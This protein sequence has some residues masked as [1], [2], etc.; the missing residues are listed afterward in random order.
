MHVFNHFYLISVLCVFNRGF[1]ESK[2][3]KEEF[4]LALAHAAV[5]DRKKLL[6]PVLCDEIKVKN[7]PPELK[8][9][10]ETHTYVECEVGVLR[11]DI[12]T[13]TESESTVNIIIQSSHLQI[14]FRVEIPRFVLYQEHFLI[15]DLNLRSMKQK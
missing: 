12:E 11:D 8:F 9:Y 1:T 15:L 7:L 14:S 3:C 6:I 4:R 5:N 10:L 13:K 2:W